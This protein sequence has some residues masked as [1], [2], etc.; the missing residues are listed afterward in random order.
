MSSLSIRLLQWFRCVFSFILLDFCH[1][2][3]SIRNADKYRLLFPPKVFLASTLV[4]RLHACMGRPENNPS[5]YELDSMYDLIIVCSLPTDSSLR[6]IATFV[7]Q[8]TRV[9]FTV[10]KVKRTFFNNAGFPFLLVILSEAGL[11]FQLSRRK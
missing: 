3:I 11:L 10:Y 2:Y 6:F 7:L 5:E 9:W 8:L 1:I 4:Q